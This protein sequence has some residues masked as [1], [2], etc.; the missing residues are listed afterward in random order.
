M[1]IKSKGS[2]FSSPL[3]MIQTVPLLL[4]R[5]S[6]CPATLSGLKGRK[7]KEATRRV[8]EQIVRRKRLSEKEKKKKFRSLCS[9]E[10][11]PRFRAE[12]A[13]LDRSLFVAPRGSDSPSFQLRA[14]ASLGLLSN[15]P[16]RSESSPLKSMCFFS[17]S[18]SL[19]FSLSRALFSS[20]LSF[21][22]SSHEYGENKTKRR[23]L[24]RA[25]TSS[26]KERE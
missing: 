22:I 16:R 4:M 6:K 11:S 10:D 19:L 24:S 13:P 17:C 12:P 8:G 23:D 18:L 14:D 7:Q 5:L 25:R 26:E 15:S 9:S 2:A 21:L 3:T 1:G 20:S